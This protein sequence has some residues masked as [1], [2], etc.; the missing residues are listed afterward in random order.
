MGKKAVDL[1]DK[2]GL[3][4]MNTAIGGHYSEDE[5]KDAFMGNIHDLADYAADA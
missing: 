3:N 2:L 4:L 1:C 5:N